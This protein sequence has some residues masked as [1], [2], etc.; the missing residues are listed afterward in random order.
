MH[1]QIPGAPTDGRSLTHQPVTVDFVEH[2]A[3]YKMPVLRLANPMPN[4][5]ESGSS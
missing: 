3:R 2:A 1:A 4:A 5:T